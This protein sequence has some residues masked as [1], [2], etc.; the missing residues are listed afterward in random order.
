MSIKIVG[1]TT[2]DLSK[3][4]QEKLGIKCVPFT[5]EFGEEAK[6]DGTFPNEEMFEYNKTHKEICRS[7]AVNVGE[8]DEFFKEQMKDGDE[9]IY[10][11]I[12]SKLS[13][14]Y[15][16]ASIARDDNEHIYVFD[17][18]S[19]SLGIALQALKA[20]EMAEE[21]KSMKEIVEVLEQYR[22]NTN[23]SLIV[24]DLSFFAKGG[25]ISKA[26]ALGAGLLKFH[27]ILTMKDGC[28]SVL[29]KLV[30]KIQKLGTKYVDTILEGYDDIDYSL[31]LVGYTSERDSTVDDI[32][33]ELKAKGFKEVIETKT[34][35]TNAV[36]SGPNTY[37][38]AY[39]S[40]MKPGKYRF[41]LGQLSDHLNETA[42]RKSIEK[43]LIK[44][45][46]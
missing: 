15:Q 11:S 23:V 19:A 8:A 13:S 38:I 2:M 3:E 35:S 36:H 42:A 20:K 45:K 40:S 37:G 17:S 33:N 24:D 41:F 27:P 4:A 7:S 30:G 16:N 28:F 21:G 10:F 12:S 14:G 43:E 44:Y 25:R 46:Q 9:L 22:H 32:V 29:K 6:K 31:A 5:I 18:E 26:S 39:I 1:D 34:N